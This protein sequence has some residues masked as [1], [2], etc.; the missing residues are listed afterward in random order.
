MA[1]LFIH[2]N[3]SRCIKVGDISKYCIIGYD[4]YVG[5]ALYRGALYQTF[6]VGLF[7]VTLLQVFYMCAKLGGISHI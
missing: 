7:K 1:P 5:V 2:R 3:L 4:R 6:T